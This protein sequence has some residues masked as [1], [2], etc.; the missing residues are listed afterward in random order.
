MSKNKTVIYTAIFGGRDNLLE[1]EYVPPNCDFVCF[2][3]QDFD[4][5]VWDVHKVDPLFPEDPNRSAKIYKILPHNFFPDHDQSVWIDGNLKVCGDINKIL[6]KYLSDANIAFYDHEYSKDSRGCI[7]KEAEVLISMAENGKEK[8]KPSL[9]QEQIQ[10]YKREGY[11]ENNGLIVGMII[12]RQHNESDVVKT[13]EDWWEEIE[14][15]TKRDQLSFNYVAW[16]NN[17]E[18]SYIKDDCRDNEYFEYTKH[19]SDKLKGK[20]YLLAKSKDVIF[21]LFNSIKV[22]WKK[23]HRLFYQ[24]AT[25]NRY[26]KYDEKDAL[27]WRWYKNSMYGYRS[28]VDH[29]LEPF[30]ATDLGTVLDIGS[31]DGLVDSLL[32][33]KGFSVTGVEPVERGVEI[34]EEKVPQLKVINMKATN[35]YEQNTQTYDYLYSLNTIEHVKNYEIF[36]KLMDS[37]KNFAV[38]VTDNADESPGDE[39][40]HYKEFTIEELKELFSDFKVEEVPLGTKRFIG[41]KVYSNR[42]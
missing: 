27:H 37:I 5:N 20:D 34:A 17:L 23:I 38:I 41:I 11:P 42:G 30:K 32:I 24:I 19:L 6:E 3:D 4:S 13:M 36:P 12:L 15:F 21:Y 16:K 33:D 1:P 22:K 9:V 2:T 28:L 35:F 29:S 14:T 8:E 25:P 31:G 40:F 7:Y 10:N 39:K 26:S 18:F